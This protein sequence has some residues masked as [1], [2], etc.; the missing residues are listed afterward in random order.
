ME[1]VQLNDYHNVTAIQKAVSNQAG[2]AQLYLGLRGS[3]A[4]S[5]LSSRDCG[6][7][8][9]VI[10]TVTMDKFFQG[11]GLPAIHLVKMDIEGW[12]IEALDGMRSTIMRNSPLNL[13]IEF[14][15]GGLL[16]RNI[17]PMVLIDKLT[18]LGLTI[19]IIDEETGQITP[20]AQYHFGL[21]DKYVARHKTAINLLCRK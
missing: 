12:E 21:I 3:G 16:S 2:T 7:D 19:S 15:P 18:E 6:K 13:I 11:E 14:Y 4:H 8:T 1:N 5:L 17:E 9:I 10:E 20:F